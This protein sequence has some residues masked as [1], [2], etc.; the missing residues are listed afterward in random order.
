MNWIRQFLSR[1]HLERD[2]H[3]EIRQ[4]LEQRIEELV[5]AG[6]SLLDAAYQ[7][8]REFGN[9]TLLEEKSREVWH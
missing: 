2:L 5:A 4:H 3:E 1:R 7:A 9:V 8:R 6:M